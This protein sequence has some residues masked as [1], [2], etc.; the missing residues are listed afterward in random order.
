MD[1]PQSTS[2]THEVFSNNETENY[3]VGSELGLSGRFVRNL[4]GAI[5]QALILLPEMSSVRFGDIKA[6]TSSGGAVPD[7]AFGRVVD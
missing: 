3:V 7:I 4:C 6:L 1:M 2:I 5:I